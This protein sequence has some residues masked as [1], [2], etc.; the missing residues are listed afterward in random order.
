MIKI[1]DNNYHFLKLLTSCKNIYTTEILST[2]LKTLC[3]QVPCSDEFFEIIQEENY[4]ETADYSFVIKELILED[5]DFI[6]VRCSANIEEL[7]G[8][9]FAIF[10]CLQMGLEQIYEY[11]L[12]K[13]E[14]KLDYQ[15]KDFSIGTY[16]LPHTTGYEM[17]RQIAE[18]YG[19]ELWFDTK[20]KIL[21]VYD[22]MGA[23]FGAYFSN[24]LNL[25]QLIKQSSSY[26]YATVVFPIGKNGLTIRN[27][28]NGKDYLENYSY[29]NKAI[30][31][32][33]IDEDIEVAEILKMKAEEY[34]TN[35]CVPRASYKLKLASLGEDVKL[36]DIIYI[37][38]KIK[39]IKQ[40]QRVVKIVRYL[41]E[42]ERSS[43]EISNLQID[44]ARSFVEGQKEIK[45][46]IT[47][48]KNLYKELENEIF[49]DKNVPN[50]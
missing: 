2:G 1:Y 16:Q 35:A 42:P 20:N 50:I 26:D 10:D 25:K 4:V 32:Y 21:R 37:V 44:F 23:E 39:Q 6:E 45:K 11:C 43:V 49:Q 3:F 8:R 17:I 40:K 14:W 41:R 33:F 7:T 47:Y 12:S 36:G 46:E 48:L 15:S 34:L 24:E 38:D 28:N 31:K 13:S 5:N 19:Q 22:K 9:V 30:E 27:I 18:D 29:T